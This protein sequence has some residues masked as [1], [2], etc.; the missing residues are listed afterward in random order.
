VLDFPSFIDVNKNPGVIIVGPSTAATM[1]TP[2]SVTMLGFAPA[3]VSAT[4]PPQVIPYPDNTAISIYYPLPPGT[5]TGPRHLVL[6]FGT[7]IYVMPYSVNVVDSGPPSITS[8]S[9]NGDGTL[10]IGGT[11]LGPDSRIFFDSM[12]AVQGPFNGNN[13]VGS[14][15][16]TPPQG[17][18]GQVATVTAYNSDGQN[19]LLL[20]STTPLILSSAPPTYTYPASVAG[21]ISSVTPA[22]LPAGSSAAVDITASGTNF[23]DG[24]VSVGFGSG[25]VTVRRVWVLSPTH[26][27]ANVVVAPNAAL[28][29]SELSIVSGMQVVSQP[30]GFLVQPARSGV[31]TIALPVVN[32]AGLEQLL[33]GGAGVIYGQNLGTLGGVTITLNSQTAQPVFANGTQVNFLVPAGLPTG[34][35]TLVL[36]NGGASSL[37]VMVQINASVPGIAAVSAPAGLLSAGTILSPD[38]PITITATGLDAS[39]A[40]N[41]VGRL[42]V[43]IA[44]VDMDVQQVTP[45]AAGIFQIQAVITQSFGA[46]QVPLAVIVDG[47]CSTTVNGVVK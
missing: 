36:T 34:P 4:L 15:Q 29:F 27:V 46:G 1:P 26:L 37:P 8:V 40:N 9:P 35:A 25:D 10:T 22:S 39:L 7:D 30:N 45:L 11:N 28:G 20:N 44:G 31:P 16:V 17:A 13:A 47:A 42:R 23:V 32:P 18:P 14:I 43:T 12:Q 38:D 24:Q 19:S 21:Q 41:Y 2:Q 6:N 3:T 33:P 5:P